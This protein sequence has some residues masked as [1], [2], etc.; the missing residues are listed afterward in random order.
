MRDVVSELV[1]VNGW[2]TKG[3]QLGDAMSIN[4]AMSLV[5]PEDRRIHEFMTKSFRR[6]R[7]FRSPVH[8]ADA[9][10]DLTHSFSRDHLLSLCWYALWTR[11]TWVMVYAGIYAE[12]HGW[13]IGEEGTYSQHG[14]TP[15]VMWAMHSVCKPTGDHNVLHWVFGIWPSWL[16]AFVQLL[17]ARSV[18]V[19]YRLNLCGEMALIA[20][21]TGQ[22]NWIW[23]RV[24]NKCVERQPDNLYYL[25]VQGKVKRHNL[26]EILNSYKDDFVMSDKWCWCGMERDP[27]G[28]LEACGGDL[29]L[30][31][32]LLKS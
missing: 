30:L 22:W 20:R 23:Q 12:S 8:A 10:V 5:T 32:R 2:L 25:F 11:Q 28:K 1:W 29:L 18:K 17:S 6:N 7:P 19:G 3:G 13:K 24:I 31:S 21:L 26:L 16:I 27:Y 9:A 15:N 4:A 14:L